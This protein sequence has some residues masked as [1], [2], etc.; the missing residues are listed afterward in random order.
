M[1]NTPSDILRTSG[2][3]LLQPI[4]FGKYQGRRVYEVPA[5]YYEYI[6]RSM[7]I[8]PLQ[9]YSKA[10]E[11]KSEYMLAQQSE[12]PAYSPL[13]KPAD[14]TLYRHQLQFI[15][16]FG[17]A[18]YGALFADIG[19]GKTRAMLEMIRLRWQQGDR[20]LIFCPKS[21]FSSWQKEIKNFLG[22][23]WSAV[24]LSGPTKRKKELLM[25]NRRFYITNYEAVLSNAMLKEFIAGGFTWLVLDESHKIK[26]HNAQTTKSMFQLA[27]NIEMRFCLTGTPI[28]NTEKDIWSQIT[29][30]DRGETFGTSFA[31]FYNRY[32]YR[33]RFGYYQGEFRQERDADLQAKIRSVSLRVKKD[34]CLDLPERTYISREVELTGKT[35]QKYKEVVNRSILVLEDETIELQYKIVELKRL[36][37]ICGGGVNEHR[38]GADKLDELSDLLDEIHEPVVIVAIYKAEIRDIQKLCDS[39]GR[40][41]G[42]V[43]GS[44]SDDDREQAIND[45]SEKKLDVIILQA[46]AGGIGV[47]GLQNASSTMIFYSSDHRWDTREQA[48]GRIHRSGQVN[49]C[50]YIDLIASLPE[51]KHT[52]DHSIQ[53]A[54]AGKDANIK[55]LIDNVIKEAQS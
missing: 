9:F 51:G 25:L 4:G 19:T 29:I 43:S 30:L 35:L 55:R 32:F 48:E 18:N 45:F 21:V 13:I 14:Q 2:P 10:K 39:T 7:S 34:D 50:T 26:T 46:Q 44:V 8:D 27:I 37:Q 24:T 11:A 1:L 3:G 20:V 53:A 12:R 6:A 42:T 54:L 28:T 41:F 15:E 49:H 40:T 38:F 33:G 22:S 52:I 47:N 31:K 5:E 36:H 16:R 17:S 23:G